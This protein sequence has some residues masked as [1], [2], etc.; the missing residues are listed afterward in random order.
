MNKYIYWL[1]LVSFNASSMYVAET[2]EQQ[3]DSADYV[4]HVQVIEGKIH[5]FEQIYTNSQNPS[6]KHI[7]QER[8]GFTYQALVKESFKGE[9][10]QSSIVEFTA[11]ESFAV[12]SDKLIFLSKNSNAMMTDVMVGSISDDYN[13]KMIACKKDLPLLYSM[14]LSTADFMDYNT[15]IQISSYDQLPED[16]YQSPRLLLKGEGHEHETLSWKKAPK[17][18]RMYGRYARWNDLRKYIKNLTETN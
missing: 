4:L 8:C 6:I 3:I 14:H 15:W 1:L 11:I 2:L 13:N 10:A 12:G 9:L 5:Q 17:Q 16:I 18:D 7:K